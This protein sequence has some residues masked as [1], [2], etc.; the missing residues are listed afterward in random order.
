MDLGLSGRTALITGGDSGIGLATAGLLLGEGARVIIS[1]LDQ[2][3]LDR[4]AASLTAGADRDAVDQRLYA[5]AA[6]IT[7]PESIARLRKEVASVGRLDILINSA[8]VTGA[9][10]AFHEIDDDGWEDT[11]AVDLMGPV[12]VTRAF[13]DDL[14]FS[15]HGRLIFLTS[16][17]AI[18][19]YPEEI[20]YDAAKA[21]LLAIS[22]GLSK[23]YGSDNLL[24]NC[25]SPA[26]IRTPMTD[27]MMDKRADELG[28][29]TMEAVESF[30]AE[31]R[32]NIELKRRGEPEEVASVIAFL[33]SERASFI[34]GSDYR[35]DA[36]S[37]AS[38]N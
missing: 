29:S 36:G 35:V 24:I 30:L 26:F 10:G 22:K 11:L 34:T 18:Q 14:R 15:G 3:E 6:D 1:D 2:A 38:I 9:T 28:V 17:N 37:V 12:R 23:T 21:A 32:P 25:V 16:E 31:K 33:C 7:D 20:P 8:G 5:I 27:A 4:A 13:L 19:P